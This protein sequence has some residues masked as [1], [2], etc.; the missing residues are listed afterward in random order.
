[1]QLNAFQILVLKFSNIILIYEHYFIRKPSLVTSHLPVCLRKH[2]CAVNCV[3]ARARARVFVCM[4]WNTCLW[5]QGW[6]HVKLRILCLVHSRAD[7][8]WRVSASPKRLSLAEVNMWLSLPTLLYK[9][10]LTE[11]NEGRYG[12]GRSLTV[13]G[14]CGSC[15][16]MKILCL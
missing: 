13:R 4:W 2:R 7:P 9:N 11:G 1:M 16:S 8:L 14:R 5:A 3:F 12:V 10:R 6:R 15:N